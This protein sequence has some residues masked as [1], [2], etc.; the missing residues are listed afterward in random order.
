[1]AGLGKGADKSVMLAESQKRA[2]DAAYYANAKKAERRYSE[3]L[4]ADGTKDIKRV[5]EKAA[6]LV[7]KEKESSAAQD[8]ASLQL[9][10][11]R[12]NAAAKHAA[13]AKLAAQEAIQR[14]HDAERSYQR[15]RRSAMAA[16]SAKDSSQLKE[17]STDEKYRDMKEKYDDLE[18]DKQADGNKY[19]AMKQRLMRARSNM[20]MA[21][22]V[23]K[24]SKENLLRLN[25]N[26]SSMR[27]KAAAQVR[28]QLARL[29][30]EVA[31]LK[32][33]GHKKAARD[34]VDNSQIRSQKRILKREERRE[35]QARVNKVKEEATSDLAL[36]M[37]RV[38]ETE[39]DK[40]H[41]QIDEAAEADDKHIKMQMRTIKKKAEKKVKKKMDAI[42]ATP[43]GKKDKKGIGV[44][45]LKQDPLTMAPALKRV[46][47]VTAKLKKESVKRA[48]TKKAATKTAAGP[49][50]ANKKLKDRQKTPASGENPLKKAERE[51]THIKRVEARALKRLKDNAILGK[52]KKELLEEK[53]RTANSHLRV[54]QRHMD[55]IDPNDDAAVKREAAKLK[56]AKE[57]VEKARLAKVK[58]E[59][60]ET[61]KKMKKVQ[62]ALNTKKSAIKRATASAEALLADLRKGAIQETKTKI[63]EAKIRQDRWAKQGLKDKAHEAQLNAED[64]VSIFHD[65]AERTEDALARYNKEKAR[66]RSNRNRL[67]KL[68]EAAHAASRHYKTTVKIAAVADRRYH[69]S[70]EEVATAKMV[71]K[72]K[73]NLLRQKQTQFKEAEAAK[74]EVVKEVSGPA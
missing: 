34:A 64:T 8:K 6:L 29:D 44:N 40:L 59:R 49:K 63:L 9:V 25:Q 54:V 37:T 52:P 4:E 5:E 11:L 48:Q 24:K 53:Y 67:H 30:E 39:T 1:M 66:V 32:A 27:K 3:A 74:A 45:A 36:E 71:A 38:V 7:S 60:E 57:K 2:A 19:H 43:L 46:F 31:V 16:I 26:M 28:G 56:V 58:G 73:E 20:I 12:V 65:L 51:L 18:A 23:A 61:E 35:L 41:A 13:N 62:D 70:K 17:Q 72:Q 50:A 47:Q 22:A 10:S 15:A 14:E 42:L 55:G 21:K 33:S 69:E 68:K